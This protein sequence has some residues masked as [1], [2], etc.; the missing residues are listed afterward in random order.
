[1]R[2][3]TPLDVQ[4]LG[5]ENARNHG[6]VAGLAVYDPSTAPGGM[7]LETVQAHVARRLGLVPPFRWRLV[8][9]PLGLGLPYWVDDP[10]FDLEYHVREVALPAPGD[11]A[12]LAQQVARLHARPLD[13]AHPLWEL[14]VIS[15]LSG[16]RVA[17]FTKVHHAAVDGMSGAEILT[18]LLDL[19]PEGRDLEE[20]APPVA[21]GL[22]STLGMLRRGVLGV[23]RYPLR[24]LRVLPRTLAHLDGNPVARTI[25]GTGLVASAA[26]TVMRTG[27]GDGGVLEMPSAKAERTVFNE[28]LTPHR[29][30]SFASLSLAEV[31]EVKNAFGVTVNDVVV[32]LCA[33]ALREV[34]QAQGQLPER[35]LVAMVPL[36]VRT[37]EQAGT[38]GNRVSAMVVP[39]PTSLADPVA[40]L[41]RAHE[42]LD[43]AKQRHRAMP[44]DVMVDTAALLPSAFV[45]RASRLA[46][47]LMT[48]LPLEPVFN[49]IVSNV[50]GPP[51][52]L[53]FDGARLLAHYPVSAINDLAGL[54][55]TVLSYLDSID[56]GV[57]ADRAQLP[58]AWPVVEAMQRGLADLL[59]AARERAAG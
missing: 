49:I 15:G 4:F 46:T 23:P 58:D 32:T 52:P 36:S 37:P 59:E 57:V 2:Q 54:N 43:S 50:P 42:V 12:Q 47:R 27:S 53:W 34:L 24:V 39:V 10:D 26:R 25:P 51:F 11:D 44:A 40:R 14:Y 33:A 16:G 18:A 20:A 29:R 5:L 22:P 13:R 8:Q 45:G 7:T 31:K 48:Q 28:L 6:H 38:Y 9:V 1:M 17:L 30:V 21:G 19:S 35:D 41:E 56:V 3:L 55:I